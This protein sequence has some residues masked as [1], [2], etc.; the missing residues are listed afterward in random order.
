MKNKIITLEQQG[1][2][3]GTYK[4]LQKCLEVIKLD[5]LDKYGRE[6]VEA[7]RS[8]TP[9]NTGLAA[10]S[11]SYEIIRDGNNVSL[12]WH[13]SDIEN[14]CNVVILIQYGHA[15]K[16]GGWVEGR[17]FVNPTIVPIFDKIT[18]KIFKEVNGR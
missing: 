13:N 4:F 12:Q 17:D 15:T 14:G 10:E 18:E 7:L 3:K 11:W 9:I 2:F 5:F 16:S 6:G 1:D 8:A